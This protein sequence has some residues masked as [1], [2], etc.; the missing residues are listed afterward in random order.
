MF[1]DIARQFFLPGGQTTTVLLLFLGWGLLIL[2]RLGR[3]ILTAR[4]RVAI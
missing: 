3:R 2:H 4:G 1:F